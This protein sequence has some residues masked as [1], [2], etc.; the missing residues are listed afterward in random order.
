MN[1]NQS[2]N[3]KLIWQLKAANHYQFTQHGRCFNVQRGKELKRTMVGYSIGYCI[4]GKFRTL[5]SLRK[6]LEKIKEIECQF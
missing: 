3:I 5:K 2:H 1:N 6:D 4:C